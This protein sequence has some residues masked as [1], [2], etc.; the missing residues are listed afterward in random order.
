MILQLPEGHGRAIDALNK[1]RGDESGCQDDAEDCGS[2]ALAF[3]DEFGEHHILTSVMQFYST[4]LYGLVSAYHK[5]DNTEDHVRIRLGE[6]RK[7]Y[8]SQILYDAYLYKSFVELHLDEATQIIEIIQSGGK[9]KAQLMYAQDLLDPRW[10][11]KRDSI[12]DRDGKKCKRCWA[13]KSL[14]VHHIKYTGKPW[15]A[16]DKDLITLCKTCHEKEHAK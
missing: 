5:D 7:L 11:E 13:T 4:S 12:L 6:R 3:F 14:H 16:P 9:T 8:I 1:H 10:I 15:E 2:L